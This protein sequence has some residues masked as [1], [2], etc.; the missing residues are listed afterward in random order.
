MDFILIFR[1]IS[2]LGAFYNLHVRASDGLFSA[3]IQVDVNLEKIENPNFLF[4]KDKY[5][6]STPENSTKITIIG[7]VNVIGNFLAENVEFRILNPTNLFEIGKTSGVIKTKGVILDR[8]SVDEYV[9]IIEAVSTLYK[10]KENNFRRA[11]TQVVIKILDVNDNCPIFVN[12]PYYA[13]VSIEDMRGSV[14]INIKAIDLDAN[15]N[16]EVRYEMKKGNGE[17]FKIDRKSGDI[18]LKQNIEKTD[19]NY[20]IIVA[21]Y[22]N[23]VTP[24]YAEVSVL[25]KVSKLYFF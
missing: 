18:S 22:D 4:Q 20:E 12:L 16:G 10:N 6:F 5:E 25:I 23:A 17:L 3:I 13:T 19:K 11:I 1:N 8:E 15:E 24:C 2:R 9:L 14:I 21:A 7:I